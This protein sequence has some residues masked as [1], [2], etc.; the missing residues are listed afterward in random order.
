MY[1][2]VGVRMRVCVCVCVCVRACVRACVR[3]CVCVRAHSD[4]PRVLESACLFCPVSLSPVSLPTPEP[5][6]SVL[7]AAFGA[8]GGRQGWE[9]GVKFQHSRSAGTDRYRA[10]KSDRV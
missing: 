7:T 4:V 6:P 2:W 9:V 8:M 3:M 1:V 10:N 5:A